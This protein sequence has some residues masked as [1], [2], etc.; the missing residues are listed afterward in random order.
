MSDL[1]SL[2]ITMLNFKSFLDGFYL[3]R[4]KFDS[5]IDLDNNFYHFQLDF[6]TCNQR[7]IYIDKHF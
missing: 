6:Y 5:T 3:K 7:L 2:L 1:L 4:K